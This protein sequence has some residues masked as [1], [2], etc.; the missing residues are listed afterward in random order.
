MGAEYLKQLDVTESTAHLD[1]FD[2]HH[3]L[4]AIST[5]GNT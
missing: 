1:M 5:S 2:N 4:M 3:D